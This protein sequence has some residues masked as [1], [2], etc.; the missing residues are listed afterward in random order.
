MHAKEAR[1]YGVC[2][3][4]FASWLTN[5]ENLPETQARDDK[6]MC[7]RAAFIIKPHYSAQIVGIM[8]LTNPCANS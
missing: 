7:K 5:S 4:F 8:P 3:K 1:K 6:A 2:A